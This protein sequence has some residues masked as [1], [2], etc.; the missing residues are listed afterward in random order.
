MPST[1]ERPVAA[2]VVAHATEYPPDRQRQEREPDEERGKESKAQ[3]P[4]DQT[5]SDTETPAVLIDDHHQEDHRLDGVAAYTAAAQHAA[6]TASKPVS[7]LPRTE[8][9]EKQ[10]AEAVRHAYEDHRGEI[11]QHEVN[12]AT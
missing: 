6:K 1:I 9:P 11:E 2:Q 12:V 10:S 4:E 8:P 7:A 3:R 5:G